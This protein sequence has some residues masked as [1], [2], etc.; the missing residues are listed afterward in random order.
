MISDDF[1][2]NYSLDRQTSDGQRVASTTFVSMPRSKEQLHRRSGSGDQTG[3]NG[4]GNDHKHLGQFTTVLGSAR[5]LAD[6]LSRTE[7]VTRQQLRSV[8]RV[9]WSSSKDQFSGP[10]RRTTQRQRQLR[11]Q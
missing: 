9:S 2:I 7:R 4:W 8:L 11:W 1:Q 5:L 6:S 10:S 3:R